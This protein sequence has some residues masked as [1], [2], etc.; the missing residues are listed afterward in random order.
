MLPYARRIIVVAMNRKYGNRYVDIRILVV[1]V[2]KSTKR[3][4]VSASLYDKQSMKQ[5][6]RAT[7]LPLEVFTGITQHFKLAW[8]VSITIHP[9]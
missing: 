1:N 9:Q 3:S 7:I 5:R 8:L 6:A 2:V 4:K